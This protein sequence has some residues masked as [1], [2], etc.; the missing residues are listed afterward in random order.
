MQEFLH[1]LEEN[2]G[3]DFQVMTNAEKEKALYIF[4][5]DPAL[6]KI[7]VQGMI[8]YMIEDGHWAAAQIVTDEQAGKDIKDS[9]Y[10]CFESDIVDAMEAY[11]RYKIGADWLS[12]VLEALL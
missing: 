4:L 12:P 1:W 9:T 8:D 10:A 6:K 7:V 5:S 3:E 11:D 2:H